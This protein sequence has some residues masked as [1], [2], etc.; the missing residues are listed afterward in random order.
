MK[1]IKCFV[2]NSNW[3]TMFFLP[4]VDLEVIGMALKHSDRKTVGLDNICDYFP[5]VSLLVI[6][7]SLIL[8]W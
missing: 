3:S 1:N 2:G 6:I 7:R 4:V 5:R 8:S